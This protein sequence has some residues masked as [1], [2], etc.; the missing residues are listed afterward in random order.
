MRNIQW[1]VDQ[2][3]E[4]QGLLMKGEWALPTIVYWFSVGL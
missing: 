2:K 1:N 4:G 3:L